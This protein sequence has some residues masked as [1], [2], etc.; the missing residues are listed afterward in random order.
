MKSIRFGLVLILT[1]MS[2]IVFAQSKTETFKV[3]GNCG[4]CKK[5]IEKAVAV[6]GVDSAAWNVKTKIMTV[7]FDAS[8]ISND[9][10]QKKIAAVGHDTEKFV[11]ENA[12]YEKLP[13][14]CLYERGN[15]KKETN[16]EHSNH[17]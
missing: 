4:M 14:C 13:G 6:S 7:T 10:I 16:K 2:A 1:F 11:A 3:S 12:V 17:H 5:R 15:P 8:K 9:D